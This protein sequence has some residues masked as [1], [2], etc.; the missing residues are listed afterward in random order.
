VSPVKKGDGR[1]SVQGEKESEQRKI[2]HYEFSG[3]DE[4]HGVIPKWLGA[5]YVIL[6]IWM[7]YYLTCF[8]T[9]KG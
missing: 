9:D 2:S 6:L 3:I 4:R 8:W 7:V 5:V 1:I